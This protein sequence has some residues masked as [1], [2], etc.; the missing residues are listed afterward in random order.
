MRAFICS[1]SLVAVFAAVILSIGSFVSHGSSG[2]WVTVESQGVT[3]RTLYHDGVWTE[4]Q[5]LDADG[6]VA[7]RRWIDF[8]GREHEE[9]LNHDVVAPHG[10]LFDSDK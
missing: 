10:S 3:T 1:V 6:D 2:E 9:F 5:R 7:Y 8:S 4:F